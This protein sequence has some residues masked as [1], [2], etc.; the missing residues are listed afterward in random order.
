MHLFYSFV[1]LTPVININ[2]GKNSKRLQWNTWG[3]GGHRFMKKTWSRKS[4]VRLS[5]I[6]L[7]FTRLL[8]FQNNALG[9]AVPKQ[10]PRSAVPKQYQGSAVPKQYQGSAVPKQYH[11]A[12]SQS[13]T[14]AH[15]PKAIPCSAVTKQ[16][17]SSAVPKQYQGSE[18]PKQYPNR[19]VPKQHPTLKCSPPSP[20]SPYWPVQLSTL[21]VCT[22][23]TNA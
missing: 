12:Q 23:Y 16:Y 21:L 7:L 15:S 14:K 10:Y 22:A 17:P 5:L 11:A 8:A 2:S 6:Y 20:D 19:A 9:S 1:L 18:V 4:R 13:N 3:R